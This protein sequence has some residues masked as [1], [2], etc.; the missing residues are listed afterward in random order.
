MKL[1]KDIKNI[2][3]IFLC[4]NEENEQLKETAKKLGT[5]ESEIIREGLKLFYEKHGIKRE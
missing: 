3:K 4:N 1:K 2:N 5:Y